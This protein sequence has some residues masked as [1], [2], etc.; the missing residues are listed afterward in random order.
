MITETQE[1]GAGAAG[2]P[3]PF[4]LRPHAGPLPQPE[5][6]PS[7]E[8]DSETVTLKAEQFSEGRRTWTC[9]PGRGGQRCDETPVRGSEFAAIVTEAS[10]H[11]SCLSQ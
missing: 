9:V 3:S 4:P 2:L 11:E 6:P 8:L 10:E 1:A 5:E 7:A